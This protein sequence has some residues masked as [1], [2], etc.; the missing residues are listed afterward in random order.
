M[1]RVLMAL[2]SILAGCA[3]PDATGKTVAVTVLSGNTPIGGST[4]QTP[5]SPVEVGAA[6][7]PGVSSSALIANAA[8]ALVAN[9]AGSLIANQAAGLSGDVRAFSSLI[10][11]AAGARRVQS[12]GEEVPLQRALIYLS[13]TRERLWLDPDNGAILSTTSDDLGR[14]TFPKAPSSEALLVQAVLSGNRRLVGHLDTRGG[15]ATVSIDVAST[16]VTEMLRARAYAMGASAS[17]ATLDPGLS[18]TPRLQRLTREGLLAGTITL[19][20]LS[21][22]QLPDMVRRYLIE[23]ATRTP[24]LKEAWEDLLRED[25]QVVHTVGGATPGFAGDGEPLAKALF[26][27]P[28]DL[29]RK[30]DGT[31]LIADLG[32]DRIR[33]ISPTGVITT[34]AGGGRASDLAIAFAMGLSSSEIGDGGPAVGALLD[35]PRSMAWDEANKR[36]FIVE[37]AGRRVRMVGSDG[38]ISTVMGPDQKHLR[39]PGLLSAPEPPTLGLPSF[40]MLESSSSLLVSDI[41]GAG[42]WRLTVPAEDATRAT[43]RADRFLGIFDRPTTLPVDG[44]Q[45]SESPVVGPM[46]LCKD[47]AGNVY[48]AAMLLHV[49]L[50]VDPEGRITRFAG[51]YGVDGVAGD[52]GPARNAA[53]GYPASLAW[54]PIGRRLLVGSSQTPRIRSISADGSLVTTL[55]GK[56]TETEDGLARASRLSDIFGIL[57]ESD[58]GLLFTDGAGGRLRRLAPPRAKPLP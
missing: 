58:G 57:P 3:T 23:L 42:I 8:A 50:K 1:R 51:R 28:Q 21:I 35:D 38:R 30:P 48:A 56:G 52:G 9:S 13:D 49:I 36:L 22:S 45:A 27:S 43:W 12:V 46:Q 26:N 54:D 17:I 4:V 44:N 2:V 6:A 47:D 40:C 20:S 39:R 32:N 18:A 11:N 53:I 24:A 33:A 14:F 37:S 31:I 7:A 16:L 10:A 15:G 25:L 34:V 29:Q 19:P 5:V 41:I 55:A